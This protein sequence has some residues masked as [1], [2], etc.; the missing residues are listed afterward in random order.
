MIAVERIIN[1]RGEYQVEA[2]KEDED[3]DILDVQTLFI[4]YSDFE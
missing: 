2:D 1:N 4:E 3:K